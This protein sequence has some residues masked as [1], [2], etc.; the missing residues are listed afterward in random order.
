VAASL[1]NAIDLPELIT[2]TQGEY[3]SLAIELAMN[4]EKLAVIKLKLANNRQTTPLFDSPLFAKNLEAA[5][6]KMFELYQADFL[7]GHIH[8]N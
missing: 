7:P 3:E 8:L 1:L 2:N 6:M 4:P 5:Y